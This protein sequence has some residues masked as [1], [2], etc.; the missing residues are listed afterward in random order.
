MKILWVLS[1][2]LTPLNERKSMTFTANFRHKLSW[3]RKQNNYFCRFV[4]FSCSH[5]DFNSWT[6]VIDCGSAEQLHL[7]LSQILCSHWRMWLWRKDV[8]VC[9]SKFE[10]KSN[11]INLPSAQRFRFDFLIF[12]RFISRSSIAICSF[13]FY[14]SHFSIH[15]VSLI[16]LQNLFTATFTCV[17]NNLGGYRV[18]GDSAQARVGILL[19]V[20]CDLFFFLSFFW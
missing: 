10:Y 1:L 17:V 13:I 20:L 18:S 16:F 7:H 11:E 2:S 9:I 5:F 8:T 3:R 12:S 6:F 15:F 14:V 4:S 19:L